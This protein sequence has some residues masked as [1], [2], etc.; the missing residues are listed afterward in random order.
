MYKKIVAG[1]D[2]SDFSRAA[3]IEAA[4]WVKKHGGKL[5]LVHGIYFDEEEFSTAP[6][7]LDKRIEKGKS[8]CARMQTMVES[9][10][11]IH[12]ESVVGEGEPP[13]VILN[14]AESRE[15]DLITL[16][17]YG[18]KG[19]KRM[20]MGSVSSGVIMNSPCD[21][22]VVKKPCTECTGTFRSILLSFDGSEFSRK[23]LERACRLSKI[24]NS[25]ITA[26][27][28]I[29]RYEEM[30]GF[31]K[32]DSIR[33]GLMNEAERIIGD[34]NEIA[35]H[36]GVEIQTEI[37]EGHAADKIIESAAR[38]KNDLIVMGT[39]GWRGVNRAIM[40]STT[41]RVLADAVCPILIVR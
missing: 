12:V 41:E 37:D 14:S 5:I 3:V 22:L 2:D 33:A 18:R 13:N 20:I 27:Y 23:A 24:D 26:L 36:N 6:G 25:G 1:I 10:F 19:L 21:V 4:N 29:P 31:M 32:T 35:K 9:E 7:Q 15:A 16:G 39:H 17:T 8:L 38:N 30:I 40:G 34:A 28:V 11:G